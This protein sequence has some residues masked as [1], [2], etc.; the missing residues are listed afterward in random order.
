MSL[1]VQEEFDRWREDLH[2]PSWILAEDLLKFDYDQLI[3]D[4]RYT[5]QTG[6]RSFDGGATREPGQGQKMT[7]REFLGEEY[8]EELGKLKEGYRL[9]FFFDN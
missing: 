3:D 7:W 8:F 4:R 9:V 2:N 1:S 6:P 5:K